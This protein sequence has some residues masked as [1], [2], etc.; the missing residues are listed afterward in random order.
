MLVISPWSRGGWVN[1]EVFD[2]TSVIRFLEVRFGVAEPNIS[3]WR[4]AVCGDLTGCFDFKTPNARS[5]MPRMPGTA[6]IAARAK[7]LPKRTTPKTPGVAEPVQDKGPRLSRPL[8]YDLEVEPTVAADG[9]TLS[10]INRGKAGAVFHVYDRDHLDA[11]PHR[12]TAEPG[13]SLLGR[14]PSRGP[15]APYDLWVLGPNGFQ[16]HF[17]GDAADGAGR[18]SAAFDPARREIRLTLSNPGPKVA[19]VTVVPQAYEGVHKAASFPPLAPGMALTTRYALSRTG[20]WYDL[21]VAFGT[22]PATM[23][24]LAG[25]LETGAPSFS[26]PAMAGPALM[27]WQDTQAVMS[28]TKP[29]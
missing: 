6:A 26:D 25:R 27:Q 2:H 28:L 7:A 18:V 9:V 23:V 19:A 3:P 10:F 12:Y 22:S 14:W 11:V 4:R 8:P 20:G 5:F 16:R 29:G 15:G 13:K 1:S 17:R 21:L 24:R